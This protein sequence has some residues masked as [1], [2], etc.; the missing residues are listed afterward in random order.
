MNNNVPNSSRSAC[1]A[2]INRQAACRVVVANRACFL[3]LVVVA[4]A[5]CAA[6]GV[7]YTNDPASKL[8]QATALFDGEGRPFPAERLI[9]DAIGD[10][11]RASD[12]VGLANAYRVYGLFFRSRVL[13]REPYASHY[14]DNGFL[15]KEARFDQRYERAMH[16]LALSEGLYRNIDK[17]DML[18]NIY[19]HMG[20]ASIL[21]GNQI[22]AC[23]YYDRSVE[24][25]AAFRAESPTAQTA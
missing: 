23:Q 1:G 11:E 5:A 10:Y 7:P 3:A 4:L 20:D 9:V 17:K 8:N 14:R 18:S 19:Y 25:Q 21:Q 24:V 6:V 16:Y 12:K 15:D 13:G 22:S 2:H